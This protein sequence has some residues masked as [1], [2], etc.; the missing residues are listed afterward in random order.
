MNND[1]DGGMDE[2]KA[3]EWR[4][5]LNGDPEAVALVYAAVVLKRCKANMVELSSSLPVTVDDRYSRLENDL[6]E[7]ALVTL[8][9][10]SMVS[11]KG[12]D[13]S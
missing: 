1:D 9:E 5:L 10:K 11:V 4:H 3:A 2:V 12:G 7:I 8:P 13:D 6:L